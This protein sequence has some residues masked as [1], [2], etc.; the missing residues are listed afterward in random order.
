MSSFYNS[1][2][3]NIG[4]TVIGVL[5]IYLMTG[6]TGLFS[7]GQAAFMGIGAYTAGILAKLFDFN[8]AVCTLGALMIAAIASLVLAVPTT[9]LRRDYVGIATV[10]FSS[11]IVAL[12]NN[13][14][15]VTGGADG[16]ARIPRKTTIAMVWI[17]VAVLIFTLM[18]FKKSR[19]G[20]QCMALKTD[21][22]AAKA[23][24]IHVDRLKVLVFVMASMIAAYAGVLMAFFTT[25]VAPNDFGLNLGMEWM[26]MVFFGGVGSLTGSVI[27]CIGLNVLTQVLRAAAYYRIIFYCMIVLII[28]NFRPQGLFGTYEFSLTGTCRKFYR[29]IKKHSSGQ[30]QIQRGKK[31]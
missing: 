6:L 18:S 19:Y 9:R 30:K 12:L 17:S 23:M 10:G 1:L 26:I 7:M 2:I 3:C 25:F 21:E 24:G 28:I 8:F 15:S 4:I 11:A 27:A 14:V 5:S 20:R 13:L 22:L 29:R 31:L 16:L